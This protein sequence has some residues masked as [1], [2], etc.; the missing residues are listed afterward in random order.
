MGLIKKGLWAIVLIIA[1]GSLIGVLDILCG[2]MTDNGVELNTAFGLT[3]GI[4][5]VVFICAVL[6]VGVAYAIRKYPVQKEAEN[7]KDNNK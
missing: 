3:Y 6:F 2:R 4:I 7:D 1:A 5:A